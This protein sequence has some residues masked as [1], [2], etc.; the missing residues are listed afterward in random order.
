MDTG[1]LETFVAVVDNG[2]IAEAARRLNVTAAAVSQRIRALEQE[3][4]VELVSRSGRTVAPTQAG[5]AILSRARS[6]L[7]ELRDLKSIASQERPAGELRLGVIQTVLSGLLPGILNSLAETYPQIAVSISRQTA[8]ELYSKV[9]DG[10]L[11]AAIFPE[12]P[13]TIPKTCDWVQLRRE[14]LIVLAPL[15]DAQ[16]SPHALLASR[17]FI[18]QNRNTW[19]GRLIDG[20]LRRAKI[21]PHERFEIDGFEPIAIMVNRGFG[22]A[23]VHD[24][25]PPWPEGLSIAK[26]PVPRNPF[27]RRIGVLWMRGTLRIHLVRAFLETAGMA[28]SEPGRRTTLKRIRVSRR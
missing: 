4:G 8:A 26:I 5:T 27:E 11:D 18:R 1:F 3:I 19:A 17:P 10:E 16:R 7:A 13:F 15:S 14:P 2:S 9:L 28:L 12:P 22:V 20:Y 23:L 6:F 21:Q 25:P 24:W